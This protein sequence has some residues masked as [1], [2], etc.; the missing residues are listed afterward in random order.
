M[1]WTAV[2]LPTTSG[3]ASGGKTLLRQQRPATIPRGDSQ[4]KAGKA[5]PMSRAALAPELRSGCRLVPGASAGALRLF[6]VE[7]QLPG[8]HRTQPFSRFAGLEAPA[9]AR[10]LARRS[11]GPLHAAPP[12]EIPLGGP[13]ER[14]VDPAQALTRDVTFNLPNPELVWEPVRVPQNYG[15]EPELEQYFGPLWYRRKIQRPAGA[16][17]V[18]LEFDAVDYFADVVLDGEHL[19]RHEGYFTPFTFDLSQRLPPDRPAELLVRV[20]DPLEDLPNGGPFLLRHRKRWIKGTMN[21]HD[22]RPGGLP[23]E[24]KARWTWPVGQS[25]PSGGIVGP[26]TLRTSGP[27]KLEG[28]YVTPLD[29]AGHVHLALVLRN[30]TEREVTATV[31]VEIRDSGTTA[32]DILL[33]PG[34]NRIDLEGQIPDP[35]LWYDAALFEIGESHLYEIEATVVVD[36]EISAVERTSFGLRTAQVESA[37]RWR[38]VLNGEEVYVRAANYIPTQHWADLGEEFYTRDFELLQQAHLHSAGLHAHVQGPACYTAA[39]RMGVSL[40]QDFPLQWAYASGTREDPALIPKATA[41]AAEMAYLL[42]NHPSVV[43]YA[44]HNEPFHVIAAQLRAQLESLPEGTAA[45]A[46][47]PELQVLLADFSWLTDS[48]EDIGNYVLDLAL[49]ETLQH[50]N[51]PTTS[52]GTSSSKILLRQQ[53]PATARWGDSQEKAGTADYASR[54]TLAPEHSSGC[55]LTPSAS[56]EGLRLFPVDPIRHVHLASGAG[57]DIHEYSGTIGSGMVYN[58]G[59]HHAPF[60]SEYGSWPVNRTAVGRVDWGEPWPPEP[61]SDQWVTF[62]RAGLIGCETTEMAGAPA[63][64]PDLASFA[65]ATERKAAFV[66]KYQTEFFR[67]HRYRPY[68]GYRWHFFV[69][70][71]GWC[72]AGLL[73]VD[74]VPTLAYHA[75]QAASRPRLVATTLGDTIFPPGK[76][77]FPIYAINDSRGLWETRV[78][79]RIERLANCEVIRTEPREEATVLNRIEGTYALPLPGQLEVVAEGNIEAGEDSEPTQGWIV[80]TS[81]TALLGEVAARLTLPG[82][83]RLV[84]S[85]DDGENDFT[86]YIAPEGWEAAYGL[87]VRTGV[88]FR[89][90]TEADLP[91]IARV[92]ADVRRTAYGHFRSRRALDLSYEEMAAK[93]RRELFRPEEPAIVHVACLDGEVI[94]FV[95]AGPYAE[96]PEEL[97]GEVYRLFVHE[98]YQRLGIGTRL[99]RLAVQDLQRQGYTRVFLWAFAESAAP[100]YYE[101][102]GWQVVERFQATF[103]EEELE[104]IVFAWNLGQVIIQKPVSQHT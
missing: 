93:V 38:Y 72:G 73:D 83:Y 102:L 78:H 22:S 6:P 4:E 87:H 58:V 84:L 56:S 10:L 23:S 89:P 101:R 45:T 8:A 32:L 3:G 65:Y 47:H 2:N 64:Y 20:Q 69:N 46:L 30:R 12:E 90:G 91:G 25:R 53:R 9:V 27:V 37:P 59:M 41:M 71:W 1:H 15:L 67:L 92:L 81:E 43:Y 66:A 79:W 85:W 44:A 77:V 5:D 88:A 29:L 97:D 80:A 14:A 48:R 94:G 61:D 63:R 36:G 54:A 55:H 33:N 21:Y 60:V 51:L 39:D 99:L 70:H 95:A 18:D 96:S 50:V 49:E 62:W 74:R 68:N 104:I 52:G 17:W 75:L 76:I 34:P 7:R 13:W 98:A 31:V 24:A 86:V 16:R 42:W 26:V 11:T 82:P 100:A 57:D 35:Q 28:I 103:G 19:G 40:F